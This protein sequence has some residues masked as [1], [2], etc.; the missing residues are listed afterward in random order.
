M[1]NFNLDELMDLAEAYVGPMIDAI[2]RRLIDRDFALEDPEV[3]MLLTALINILGHDNRGDRPTEVLLMAAYGERGVLDRPNMRVMRWRNGALSGSDLANEPGLGI[4]RT[5][6][7]GEMPMPSK[8]KPGLTRMHQEMNSEAASSG[9]PLRAAVPPKRAKVGQ[10]VQ[11]NQT[12]QDLDE[13]NVE[14]KSTKK[15]LDEMTK[16]MLQMEGDRDMWRKLFEDCNKK[17]GKEIERLRQDYKERSEQMALTT[18]VEK[19]IP[20]RN[21]P[22]GQSPMELLTP[23]EMSQT[24][25]T[26]LPTETNRVT[27][28]DPS[29]TLGDPVVEQTVRKLIETAGRLVANKNAPGSGV[30]A[31]YGTIDDTG[32]VRLSQTVI[33]QGISD[34]TP[35]MG[36]SRAPE[37]RIR[38]MPAKKVSRVTDVQKNNQLKYNFTGVPETDPR[39]CFNRATWSPAVNL[40]QPPLGTSHLILGDSL[41][42]VLSNLRTS[43][44]TTVMAFGGATIAQ[45]Y[46]MV[47]LMNPGRIPNVM[48]LV[49]TNDI[50]RGSDEQEAL[51]ES[52][53]VCLFT[54]LWQKFNCAVLTV[55]TVPMNTRS[56][57]AAGRR[58][59][60]GVVRW[61]NIL[62]NLAS[63]NAG[64][65]I[66]MD[67]EHELRAMDQARLTT[68]GIHFDSIEGQAWL[69]RVFQERLDE[70]E[71]ELFDTG[72]LKEEGASNVT[73][74]TT[75]VPPSLETR[76][77]TVPAVTNYR[78]QSSSEPGQ[79]TDVQDRL[80]E[81][82]MRRTIHP[83]RRIGPVNPIE[84]TA[85]TSRSDTRSDTRSETTSN[86]REERRP[87]RGS[88]MWSRPIPSPWH[89]YKDELMKL[90]LQR[91]SFIE[92]AR[93]MLNGAT[94]SV[95][96]LY[97]ITGVDWLIAA[98]INF[99]S[100]TALRFADLEGMP[101]NNTMGPVNARPL[102]DVRLNH[103]E[104]NRE[105][106]PGR[107][108]MTKAPIGQHVKIF[109]QL[110]TPPGHVKERIYPKLV[111]QDGDAQRYSG[112]KAIKKDETIFAAYDKAEMRKAKIMIVANSEF[113]YTS[114]SLFWPDVIMLAAVDLDLLQSISLAIGVQR[115]T[116]MNPIT[117][118]FAGI[119]DHLHSRG[120]LSRLRDPTTA[121]N[122]V[123]PAIKDIL[124]SMGEVV[125]A[126][127]EGSFTRV[128]PR[129]VF[130]LSPVYAHLPDGLKFVYAIVTLLSEEKYDVI[131]SAPNRMIEMENLR[132]LKAELPA[133]WSDISNAMRGFKDHALHM[134]VLDEVLGLELSNFSRQL[135][136]KPGIDDDHRVIAAMS[137]D[138]WFRAMEVTGENTRR[139]NS[140]ETRAHLEAMVLRTKPEA[141]QWLHLNPRVAALGAD[142]FE[143][144]P[145]MITKIHAYLLKEVSLAENAEEKTAEFVNRMCQI[146]LETFWTQEVKGQEGFERTDSMLEGLGAGWTASFLAKVYPKVSHYL[147]KEFLQ[148][149]V[150]VSIVELIAL[151][152]TFGAESF[153]KGPAILLTDGI[154]NLRL[155][156][157]LT[158][159]A[160]THGNLGG[161][162]KLTRCPEQM[163]ERVRNL[164]MKKSTDSWNKI[165]DLR[166][167]L[168]QYL[169]Q[170]NRF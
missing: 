143:Q 141:N 134:L 152:V 35:L 58:H 17:Q 119:N 156:G 59:N 101:S 165:R 53:M 38:K 153:V 12:M 140:L 160:I 135:K 20:A 46:R 25:E 126:T 82:P 85:G 104:G 72:V 30:T 95:S 111:N 117:I 123:W 5:Y 151:F 98:S 80:G 147:I 92:D 96:R 90:D 37:R 49:G 60:E 43:W 41:V 150:E 144:G 159:I 102:Q 13:M 45:L 4:S 16:S 28:P 67:I 158:L 32:R 54:T 166:H 138:L 66:L 62:R 86:S 108:L 50:S 107:F 70:L 100:T 162:M 137:N 114:K 57:T 44:F 63:R 136:L 48:I 40:Q 110:T 1:D 167:T 112:L 84:E 47:E 122:A 116:D 34:V 131:I 106:R 94:L 69:N 105:E 8:P 33:R 51:W 120:F 168:I 71:A 75:F 148:A 142:A 68:D 169:L 42:R 145:V 124:E 121:E 103:D 91:V 15:E 11:T 139:K 56:L 164:D 155:D 36:S 14:L 52:M 89:V 109:R 3:V 99:S 161:L 154:Q 130:A 129:I 163:R 22:R 31:P 27:I 113:V 10:G 76:L 26:R 128:T 132:P 18:A 81:A 97:S 115:Q 2:Y 6:Q 39:A 64:R 23:R 77:G 21:I 149:V 7:P 74:I 61:N 133:V 93:R 79:R 78:Q 65:M 146:T 55:C 88:L 157:L 83:R 9:S 24:I 118:V 127:K 125:D 29:D 19:V 170:Q 87:S 73:V